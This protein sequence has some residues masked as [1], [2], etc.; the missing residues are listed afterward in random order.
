LWAVFGLCWRILFL[1][2]QLVSSFCCELLFGSCSQ[3]L[4][5]SLQEVSGFCNGLHLNPAHDMCPPLPRKWVAS[6]V[7][8]ILFDSSHDMW[9]WLSRQ[10]VDSM[11]RCIWTL[12]MTPVL[13]YPESEWHLWWATFELCSGRVSA[14]IQNVSVFHLSC[15]WNL[16][17]MCVLGFLES[18]WLLWW[19]AIGPSSWHLSSPL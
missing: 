13:I 2:L 16:F 6:M 12:L 19:A 7:S 11:V 9:P 18:E 5:S 4:P 1:T 10:W 17:T 14:S 15:F 3:W 8:C